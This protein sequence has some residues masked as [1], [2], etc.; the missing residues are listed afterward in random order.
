[1]EEKQSDAMQHPRPVTNEGASN[2]LPHKIADNRH[3]PVANHG[4]GQK[5]QGN[6]SVKD[7]SLEE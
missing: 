6:E 2:C 4:S 7:V 5:N 1:L 3:H